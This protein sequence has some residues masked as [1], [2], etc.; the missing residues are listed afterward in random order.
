MCSWINPCLNQ[1][2]VNL[3]KN[4]QKSTEE[5]NLIQDL[6]LDGK[7]ESVICKIIERISTIV[8]TKE[9]WTEM[10]IIY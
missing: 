5:E 8:I 1:C 6:K 9:T 7:F 4:G 2:I 10:I 3:S